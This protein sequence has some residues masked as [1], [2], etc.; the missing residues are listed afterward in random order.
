MF[1][2]KTWMRDYMRV[3]NTP[4]KQHKEYLKRKSK[5]N[6]NYMLVRDKPDYKHYK[7]CRQC[8]LNKPLD[9]IFCPECHSRLAYNAKQRTEKWK[10]EREQRVHRY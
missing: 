5:T 1:D 7:Y 3:Y 10:K 8:G 2:K 9:L 6:K 4:D